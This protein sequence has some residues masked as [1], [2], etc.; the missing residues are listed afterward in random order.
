MLTPVLSCLPT[1]ILCGLIGLALPLRKKA[2]EESGSDIV[3][4]KLVIMSATLRVDDFTSNAKL[5]PSTTPYVVKIPGRTFPVTIHHSK[6]TELDDYG[7]LPDT[8]R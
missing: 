5:F 2:S 1:D 3:P 8:K 4:L 7:M 6:V